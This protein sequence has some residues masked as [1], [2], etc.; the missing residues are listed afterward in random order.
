MLPLRDNKTKQK[1]KKK[2]K[3]DHQNSQIL[4]TVNLY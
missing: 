1:K 4:G 2:K 3:K